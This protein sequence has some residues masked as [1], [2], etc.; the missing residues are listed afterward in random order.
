MG[1]KEC[2]LMKGANIYIFLISNGK[3]WFNKG[4][5]VCF[6]KGCLVASG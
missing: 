1:S 6:V 4:S 3:L 2:R 5:K